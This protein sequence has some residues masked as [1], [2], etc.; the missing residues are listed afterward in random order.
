MK[1]NVLI[2]GDRRDLTSKEVSDW[3]S[4]YCKS[5]NYNFRCIDS[6]TDT[7]NFSRI[8]IIETKIKRY[9]TFNNEKTEIELSDISG[10]YFRKGRLLYTNFTYLR[11]NSGELTNI[12]FRLGNYFMAYEDNVKSFFLNSIYEQNVIGKD[13]GSFINKIW[14]LKEA[15]ELGLR[16]PNTIFSTTKI[17]LLDFHSKQKSIMKLFKVV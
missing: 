3:A 16:I 11:K 9:I 10:M 15:N 1:K 6:E 14:V 8:E 7:V 4:Y 13:N 12:K 2:I 5:L 17:Q